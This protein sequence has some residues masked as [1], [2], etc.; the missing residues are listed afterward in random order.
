MHAYLLITKTPDIKTAKEIFPS[1]K[2]VI[3]FNIKKISDTKDVVRFTSVAL[4]ENTVIFLPN[5]DMA[6]VEAQNAFLKTLEESQENL[7]FLL[8]A[9]NETL[10]LPTIISRCNVVYLK[11]KKIIEEKEIE[12]ALNFTNSEITEKFETIS[13]L[14]KRED[15]LGFLEDLQEILHLA[16]S[17]NITHKRMLELAAEAHF[18]IKQNANPALQMT[19]FVTSL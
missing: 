9:R 3:E 13:K 19:R 8:T 10:V 16:L 18:R 6:T 14:T 1:A 2:R 17:E 12:N 15:A 5:F 7:F 4:A 11:N